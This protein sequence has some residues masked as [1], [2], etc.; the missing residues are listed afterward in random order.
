MAA[1]ADQ[2]YPFESQRATWPS[3]KRRRSKSGSGSM[4]RCPLPLGDN[5]IRDT[6]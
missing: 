1:N 2:R 6:H 3:S 4:T 5:A